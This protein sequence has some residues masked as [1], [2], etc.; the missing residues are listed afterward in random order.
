M[1]K[2]GI[3]IHIP[4]CVKKCGYCD[5]YSVKWDEESENKY[6]HSAINEIKSYNELSSKYV[7]DSIYI[8]GG[9]PSIINPKNLEKIISTIRC[10]FTV[11]E[12]SE[13]SMEANPNSLWE[14]I[15]TYGEIGIN[16]LSIGIQSLNDNILKRIGRIHNSK[17]A[18]QAID[19]A[20]SFGF[21]NINADVMFNIPG[22]TVDDIN[23]T[24]S[25]LV[26]KQIRHISFYSLKL[27][28]GTPMYL[29]KKNKKIVMPEEDLERE[30]YYAGRN[31]MEKHGLM[32]YEIS[33]FSV[34][35]YECRHNLK[36]WKQEEYIGIGPSAH[37]FLGNVRFSNP[38]DLTEYITSGEN[39][40]FERN[41]LE[42][43]DENDIKFEYIMLR[44]RLTEGLKFADFKNKFSIDFKE[45][46]K[47]QIKHLTEN[48]LIESDDDAI[49]L[50]KRG[51]DLSNYVFSQ[52]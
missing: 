41:T 17:E 40:V 11:E 27:E 6:I 47:E 34:K 20:I 8:G 18:L 30:M 37:S 50:T 48:N 44:L 19:R 1:K 46:Y 12:N 9:T 39:G 51:M 49:R 13:I 31:I 3:Y 45:A 4:F 33:N 21:E 35:G 22:Q 5:F 25:K 15:K 29:L 14:N 26:T 32:Q 2:L 42:E 16:R 23:D 43:M 10:L 52:F 28:E 7:V 24:I 38:S 36:Y